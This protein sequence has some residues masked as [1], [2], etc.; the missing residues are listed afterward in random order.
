MTKIPKK[1]KY[2]Y[3]FVV[4]VILLLVALSIVR[5]SVGNLYTFFPNLKIA[6]DLV[7]RYTKFVNLSWLS[8]IIVLLSTPLFA[9]F[10]VKRK[11]YN[12]IPLYLVTI[13]IFHVLR[14][15]FIYLTPL[16]DPHPFASGWGLGVMPQGGMFPSGHTFTVFIFTLFIIREEKLRKLKFW[17]VLFIGL[18][19]IEIATLLLSR[20]HYTIDII[21]SLFIGFTLYTLSSKYLRKYFVI[22]DYKTDITDVDV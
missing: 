4:S 14:A 13:A 5:V 7:F 12:K 3:I 10:V 19:I 20:G 11:L 6:E 9:I 21:A 17:P 18:T 15:I 2:I 16:A 1:R 8:D 22:Q